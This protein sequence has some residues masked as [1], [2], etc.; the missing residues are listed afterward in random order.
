MKFG[1]EHPEEARKM[2]RKYFPNM[3]EAVFNAAFDKGIRGLPTSPILTQDQFNR[4][5]DAVNI[6][7]KKPLKA[8]YSA[9]IDT[10]FAREAQKDIMGH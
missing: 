4:T 3:D 8:D 2:T 1:K 10:T 6:T 7:A 5:I 9:L